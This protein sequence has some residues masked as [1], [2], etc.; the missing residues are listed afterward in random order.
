MVGLKQFKMKNLLLIVLLCL[1]VD[2][3]GQTI[4]KDRKQELRVER[5]IQNS[6]PTYKVYFHA[7]YLV[8]GN[9]AE[10]DY[11]L[12]QLLNVINNEKITYAYIGNTSVKYVPF[13]NQVEAFAKTSSFIL[14]KKQIEKIKNKIW[15][16]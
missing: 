5:V 4:L 1:S 7:T 11:F 3:V 8:L 6:E 2:V 13:E 9:K 10:T 15:K 16:Q 14:T 12:E